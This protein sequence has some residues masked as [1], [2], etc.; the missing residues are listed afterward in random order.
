MG[1]KRLDAISDYARHG[2]DLR[3]AC[4][5]CAHVAVLDA[6]K[7]TAL[8]IKRGWSRDMRLL[9]ARLKCG[10]CGSRRVLTGP[11]FCGECHRTYV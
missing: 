6:R 5:D 1:S 9:M 2:Y 10:K 8:C 4:S 7:L 11:A 3:V